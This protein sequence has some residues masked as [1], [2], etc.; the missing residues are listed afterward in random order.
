MSGGLVR[1][2]GV[3][4]EKGISCSSCSL[5]SMLEILREA[6]RKLRGGKTVAV[7]GRWRTTQSGER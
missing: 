7:I 1:A 4:K 3:R 2:E 5:G 6:G